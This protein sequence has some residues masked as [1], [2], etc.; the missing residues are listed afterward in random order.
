MEKIGFI[1]M[2][3]MGKAILLGALKEFPKEELL[4]CARTRETKRR[5][6][7]ETGVEYTDSNAECANQCKYLILAVKP[8]FYEEVLN[9]I[10]YMLTPEHVIISLAPGKSIEQLKMNLG[11]D[12]RIVRVMPNTPAMVGEGM[13]GISCIREELSDEEFHM[14]GRIFGA[15]GK[16][17]FIDEKLMDAVV[18]ASG[19]SPAF[20]YMFIEAL[21]DSA[22]RY[23]MPRKQAYI[24]AAQAVKGAAAMVLETGEHPGVLKDQVCSP[25]G[26]TIEGVAALEA[27][28][29]RDAV[30]KASEAVYRKCTNM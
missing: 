25:G 21:A 17:E 16:A 28:G 22:V 15:C 7:E 1:G 10:R 12:R 30:L 19:S 24:F 27:G 3:N 8:Q 9:G 13:S 4:F 11:I 20:V 23:G 26:T 2:G 18:C 29:M 5:V 6:Y 14:L